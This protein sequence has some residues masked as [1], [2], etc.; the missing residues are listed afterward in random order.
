[1][2]TEGE[3]KE[4]AKDL[5]AMANHRG[6]TGYIIFGVRDS[7]RKIVGI[8]RKKGLE[9]SLVQIGSS[10]IVPYAEFEPVWYDID[11]VSILVLEVPN[12]RLRPHWIKETGDVFVRHHKVVEKAHPPEVRR[13]MEESAKQ[14]EKISDEDDS[15]DEKYKTLTENYDLAHVNT[16]LAQNFF[17]LVGPPTLYRTCKRDIGKNLDRFEPVVFAPQYDNFV[18]TPQ[19]VETES[20]VDY[21]VERHS[22]SVPSADFEAFIKELGD[23]V[24]RV[25]RSASIWDSRLP[26]YWS[27]SRDDEMDYGV[28]AEGALQALRRNPEGVLAAVVQFSRFDLYKPTSLLLFYAD[29]QP[30]RVRTSETVIDQCWLKLLTSSLPFNPKWI[31]DIF[32]VFGKLD[33]SFDPAS[34]ITDSILEEV[35]SIKWGAKIQSQVKAPIVGFMGRLTGDYDP[36]LDQSLGLVVKTEP[37]WEVGMS[38][39]DD[40]NFHHYRNLFKKPLVKCFDEIPIEVTNP[41]PNW[42]EIQSGV[43][44]F[45]SLTIRQV[46]VGAIGRIMSVISAYSA[47]GI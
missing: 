11:N 14:E 9:E 27:L 7:D 41:M 23:I 32:G 20:A 31:Q 37:F 25:A 21:L 36:D 28:G 13:M 47:G 2:S 15:L 43:G 22:E 16:G 34:E 38:P 19:F 33:G 42:R 35:C 12:S 24:P 45:G 39:Y 26:M 18:P 10:R 5:C 1:M 29:V 8:D 30:R 6:G 3:K 17:P 44:E 40:W 4:F 46:V